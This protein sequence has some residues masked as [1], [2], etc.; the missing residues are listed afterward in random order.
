MS[1]RNEIL[2]VIVGHDSIEHDHKNLEESFYEKNN[3]NE[4]T[5]V[6]GNQPYYNYFILG[7]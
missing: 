2:T 6:E 5:I 1:N 4:L 7:E 3:D